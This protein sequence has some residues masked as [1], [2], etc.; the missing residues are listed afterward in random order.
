MFSFI[1]FALNK[2][3]ALDIG[4]V[5]HTIRVVR[6]L[7]GRAGTYYPTI[8]LSL[9]GP[10]G[11][12]SGYGPK[13]FPRWMSRLTKM[14]RYYTSGWSNSIT[15]TLPHLRFRHAYKLKRFGGLWLYRETQAFYTRVCR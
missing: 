14:D 15:I 2:Y 6:S 7:N 5:G 1:T 11:S 9:T 12:V 13:G 3:G 10:N 4:V 8:R